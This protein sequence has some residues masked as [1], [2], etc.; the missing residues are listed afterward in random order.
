MLSSELVDS[1]ELRLGDD[2]KIILLGLGL[3]FAATLPLST[4]W[5]CFCAATRRV[6]LVRLA[7]V[8]GALVRC[9]CAHAVRACW[10]EVFCSV[11]PSDVCQCQR[12]NGYEASPV[13]VSRIEGSASGITEVIF[14]MCLIL[15]CRYRRLP[16]KTDWFPGPR[17]GRR[18]RGM[19]GAPPG[20][21][22]ARN[23]YP[24]TEG[25]F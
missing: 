6:R 16:P 18:A 1:G 24:Q 13:R 11:W 10:R 20:C 4:C 5:P 7:E 23:M 21:G 14:E 19:G 12:H 17:P 2:N 8:L 15:A 9:C 3:G 22:P 25:G